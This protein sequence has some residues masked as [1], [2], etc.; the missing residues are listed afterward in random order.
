MKNYLLYTF[1]FETEKKANCH[2]FRLWQ[3]VL[4]FLQ[5]VSFHL[6]L[7]LLYFRNTP[8]SCPQKKAKNQSRKTILLYSQE[9]LFQFNKYIFSKEIDGIKK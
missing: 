7:L 1:L 9:D 4:T 3:F 8:G 6:Y 2:C 5:T